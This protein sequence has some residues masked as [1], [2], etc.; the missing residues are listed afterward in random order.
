[1][2]RNLD[3]LR[4]HVNGWTPAQIGATFLLNDR[5]ICNILAKFSE[6]ERQEA[7]TLNPPPTAPERF[8]S[9][10][11]AHIARV[12]FFLSLVLGWLSNSIDKKDVCV[13]TKI[14]LV[15]FN[16]FLAL[17]EEMRF[18]ELSRIANYFG[19]NPAEFVT[20]AYK[21]EPVKERTMILERFPHR[22]GKASLVTA[23]RCQ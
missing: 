11:L 12:G 18:T 9:T 14:P 2:E 22:R 21:Q 1:M 7:K 23:V 4:H 3:I 5:R 15:R 10:D 6:Q 8:T 19:L 17:K 16:K 13:A 20:S